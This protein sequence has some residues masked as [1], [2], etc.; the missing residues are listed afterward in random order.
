MLDKIKTTKELALYL[1]VSDE[2]LKNIDPEKSLASFYIQK[3]GSTEKRLIEY[4][5]GELSRILDR[6]CDGLQWLYPQD[7]T[8]Y[9]PA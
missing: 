7:K 3:P 5:K 2:K 6:L 8:K 9:R 1:G 4:P